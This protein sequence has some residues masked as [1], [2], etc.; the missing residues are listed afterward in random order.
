MLHLTVSDVES[1]Q[2]KI[3]LWSEHCRRFGQLLKFV[4]SISAYESIFAIFDWQN[5]IS[6]PPQS[7]RNVF[8]TNP[9]LPLN[10]VRC[11]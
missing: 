8:S 4:E 10:E 9:S 5:E 6:M 2:F 7:S 11:R 3:K 1:H